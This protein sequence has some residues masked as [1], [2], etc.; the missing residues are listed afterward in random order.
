MRT[1]VLMF[2]DTKSMANFNLWNE[3]KQGG[4]VRVWVAQILLSDPGGLE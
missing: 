4:D 1:F 2:F 3:R